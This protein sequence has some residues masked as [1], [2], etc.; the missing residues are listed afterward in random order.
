MHTLDFAAS[1]RFNRLFE[2]KLQLDNLLDASYVFDQEV[3]QTGSSVEVE[4]YRLGLG[5]EVGLSIRF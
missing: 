2:L 4:R 3:P 5:F 1:Y